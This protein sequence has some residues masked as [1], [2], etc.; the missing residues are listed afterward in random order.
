MRQERR[1]SGI[2]IEVPDAYQTPSAAA[3]RRGRV[4]AADETTAIPNFEEVDAALIDALLGQE[5]GLIDE[6]E[7]EADPGAVRSRRG[8]AVDEQTLSVAMPAAPA[9]TAIALVEQDGV[10]SWQFPIDDDVTTRGRVRR[11]EGSRTLRFEI[12]LSDAARGAG[13]RSILSSAMDLGGRI[14][15]R[16]L[17]T[18]TDAVLGL[19][20]S[21]VDR[22]LLLMKPGG[23]GKWERLKDPGSLQLPSGRPARILL[24][25]HGTFSSTIGSFS[26]LTA[27]AAGNE[28]IEDMWRRYDAVIGFDHPTLSVDP[29][30]NAVDLLNLLKRL[31]PQSLAIDAVS[32]SRG[33]LVLRSLTESLLP[34]SGLDAKLGRA[35]FVGATNDGTAL[36]DPDNWRDFIDVY[37]NLA[38]GAARAIA[39][40]PNAVPVA[41]MV[42]SVVQGLGAVVKFLVDHAIDKRGVPGLAAMQPGGDFVRRLNQTQVGQPS[43]G[44]VDYYAVTS[45]F[46]GGASAGGLA[47]E[48]PRKFLMRAAD[49]VV[50]RLMNN[51]PNDLVVDTPSMTAIDAAGGHNVGEVLDFGAN[52]VVYHT[53]YFTQ[54]VVAERL[55]TWLQLGAASRSRGVSKAE[56]QLAQAEARI[57]DA[58]DL[59][60]VAQSAAIVTPVAAS[61]RPVLNVE[62]VW[63]DIGRAQGD[64]YAV[65]HYVGV[66]PQ[67]A[68]LA[69]DR[70]VSN[71]DKEEDL[72]LTRLTRSNVLRGELGEISFFP[73]G[74]SSKR[75]RLIAVCG[76]G[77]YG[78]FGS[79][80]LRML[81]RNLAQSVAAL[82]DPRT[83]CV[84]LIG[85]GEGAM[86][87]DNAV[88]QLV[89]GMGDAMRVT[90]TSDR[91]RRV[92]IVEFMKTKADAIQATLSQLALA[93]GFPVEI[94]MPGTVVT[95]GNGLVSDDLARTLLVRAASG[96]GHGKSTP[97]S[98]DEL[99]TH[100][101]EE[102]RAAATKSEGASDFDESEERP[103]RRMLRRLWEE[104]S[105][106]IE[107]LTQV[108]PF[109]ATSTLEPQRI[110]FLRADD[111]Y[112]VS[113]ITDNA[114]IP[115]RV[116]G[117]QEGL[118]SDATVQMTDP[119]RE[120]MPDLSD[121]LFRLT[122]PRDFR[123][124]MAPDAPLIFEVDRHTASIHWEM[125]A[126][127]IGDSAYEPI[128]LRRPVARQLRT[129]YSESVAIGG[130]ARGRDINVL[131]IGDPGNPDRQ[132]NLPHARAEARRVAAFLETL[133][134]E[135]GIG[136]QVHQLIGA[137]NYAE[138]G[139]PP[140]TRLEVIRRLMRGDIDVV[141]YAGHG[142]FDEANPQKT[143]WLFHD[144]LL[145]A[146]EIERID[147]PPA[148]VVANACLT[149]RL[150]SA[151]GTGPT[152]SHPRG[153]AG[154]LPSLADEF[155]NRGV[156]N[157]VGTAW[158]I[159][160]VGAVEFAQTFYR[161]FFTPSNGE[162]QTIGEALLK[163]RSALHTWEGSQPSN[164][165]LWAA[166][167]HYG[168]P[169]F[170]YSNI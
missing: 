7:Y 29:E 151:R 38:L 48:L 14:K 154:L 117:V 47:N 9:E 169:G 135:T 35:V 26:S 124:L 118:I 68:E 150:S 165:V 62:V 28:L 127:G 73:W 69:L 155:F 51:R 10:Y 91:I 30:Q 140:A 92:R 3:R 144:G 22:G 56:T 109:Q 43:P 96:A 31:S 101:P 41:T 115:E 67:R 17:G 93:G 114:T 82:P 33:G 146:G 88:T 39:L 75:N 149:G 63:D 50:D 166:Y 54:E 24:F 77:Q 8:Q 64:I 76:M 157:Y 81:H 131:V 103:L 152:T 12:P 65:G 13:T 70:I 120:E 20:E 4:R 19:V 78:P 141:H 123:D 126:S 164:L 2:V 143:G 148:L 142:D 139:I 80:E 34:R 102:I 105:G 130:A 61:E 45:D 147:F 129:A 21:K 84:V 58:G 66:A 170:R 161:E 136:L 98:F 122:L 6:F 138:R 74:G 49:P 167:Q 55:R 42:G 100:L 106:D 5:L 85:A 86:R 57:V 97:K 72:V 44:D 119:Y 108:A 18:A 79:H 107:K 153:E 37:T 163:A 111:V 128:G 121:M 46:E 125:L 134:D 36:A 168:D 83:I 11:S 52:S 40:I 94:K 159:D 137:P 158:E 89:L 116:I 104:A 99:E 110:A 32:Y 162:H 23:V 90:G 113:A 71:S 59:P 25:V 133:S 95:G 53:V 160:D 145:T 15:G 1:P 87:P 16:I 112:K 132:E 27:L 156:R 60:A